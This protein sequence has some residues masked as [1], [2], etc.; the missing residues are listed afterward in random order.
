MRKSCLITLAFFILYFQLFVA[1]FSPPP[2]Y[3]LAF[4]LLFDLFHSWLEIIPYR[5]SQRGGFSSAPCSISAEPLFFCPLPVDQ[6]LLLNSFFVNPNEIFLCFLSALRSRPKVE[7]DSFKP[8]GVQ[9][10]HPFMCFSVSYCFG[11]YLFLF[12]SQDGAHP[13]PAQYKPI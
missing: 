6:L 4:Q 2:W 1:P 7:D 3:I 8:W 9:T 12:A 10:P 5:T 11:L 13:Q